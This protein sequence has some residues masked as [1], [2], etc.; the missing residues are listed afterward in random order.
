MTQVEIAQKFEEL[1]DTMAVSN[2]PKYMHVFGETMKKMMEW[3]VVNKPDLAQEYLDSL[4]SI[5]WKNYL[6]DKEVSA[7]ISKMDPKPLWSKEQWKQVMESLGIETE[8]SPYYNC[9]ALFVAVSMIY[10]DSAKTIAKLL[11]K[12]LEDITTEEMAEA[13]H[14]LA[15][16]KLKD[17]DAVFNIRNYF[18]L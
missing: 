3:F 7:I 1:Y 8:E 15:I 14:M 4:C 2:N 5:M 17:L 9:N 12:D 11:D 13:T 10:S 18:G 6:T 16:D